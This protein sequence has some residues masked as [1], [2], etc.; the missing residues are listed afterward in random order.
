MALVQ[1]PTGGTPRCRLG[2]CQDLANIGLG[3]GQIVRGSW[4]VRAAPNGFGARFPLTIDQRMKSHGTATRGWLSGASR[5]RLCAGNSYRLSRT[6][7]G[8]DDLFRRTIAIDSFVDGNWQWQPRLGGGG[9]A[10]AARDG[11]R[12]WSPYPG[13]AATRASM[14]GTAA[15]FARDRKNFK[16]AAT[17]SHHF[18]ARWRGN[19]LAQCCHSKLHGS[20][21]D[22]ATKTWTHDSATMSQ[23][24]QVGRKTNSYFI[25]KLCTSINFRAYQ[26]ALR[27]QKRGPSAGSPETRVPPTRVPRGSHEGPTVWATN[28]LTPNFTVPW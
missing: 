2:F 19:A 16:T 18:A 24:R 13:P 7:E 23:Y 9:G 17:F 3:L 27:A 5:S 12:L 8:Q 15:V 21:T 22:H 14:V 4:L 28:T 20:K 11:V 1:S 10:H 26:P 6:G 25:S